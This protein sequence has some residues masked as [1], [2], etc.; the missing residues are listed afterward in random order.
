M[1]ELVRDATPTRDDQSQGCR[2]HLHPAITDKRPL[3]LFSMPSGPSKRHEIHD[4]IQNTKSKLYS[5]VEDPSNDLV[6]WTPDG[7]GIVVKDREVFER[8]HLIGLLATFP[9][10]CTFPSFVRELNSYRFRVVSSIENGD[11]H[12]VFAVDGFERGKPRD[13]GGLRRKSNYGR[14]RRDEHAVKTVKA[15]GG[16][17]VRQRRALSRGRGGNEMMYLEDLDETRTVMKK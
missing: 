15:P 2:R 13:L 16:R 12:D 14:F 3:L 17:D 5:L 1:S 4:T 7:K 8:K 11:A 9:H 6:T 10:M